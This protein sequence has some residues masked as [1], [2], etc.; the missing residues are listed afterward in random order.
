MS[1]VTKT[2]HKRGCS[3]WLFLFQP[4]N[5]DI[6]LPTKQNLSTL[7]LPLPNRIW[8]GLLLTSLSALPRQGSWM[9]LWWRE[10]KDCPDRNTER[11]LPGTAEVTVGLARK[12][13]WKDAPFMK[14]QTA[15]DTENLQRKDTQRRDP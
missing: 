11:K 3:L 2:G 9:W 5:R 6:Y 10:T 7:I 12:G 1:M 4:Q 13:L 8:K 15:E 14:T